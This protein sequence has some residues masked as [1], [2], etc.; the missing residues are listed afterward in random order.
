MT[1]SGLGSQAE[2][3]GDGR[4]RSCWDGRYTA[5]Q[6]CRVLCCLHLWPTKHGA[7]E[8]G[9]CQGGCGLH[10]PGDLPPLFPVLEIVLSTILVIKSFKNKAP[11]YFGL[12]QILW[13][14]AI[15]ESVSFS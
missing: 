14:N 3:S 10:F 12:V 13:I 1:Y 5:S 4:W 2:S 11:P 15:H 8:G 6:S 9:R 7:C